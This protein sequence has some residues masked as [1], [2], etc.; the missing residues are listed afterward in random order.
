MLNFYCT[1]LLVVAV[2]SCNA[3]ISLLDNKWKPH[4]L[5]TR[6]A[7]AQV[8][9]S[10]RTLRAGTCFLSILKGRQQL[11]A[12]LEKGSPSVQER[13]KLVISA[14]GFGDRRQCWSSV[15][16]GETYILFLSINNITGYLVAKYLGAFGAAELLYGP[17]ED[18]I[19]LS[20]GWR[21]WSSWS[22]CSRGCGGGVR[23]RKRVC[24]SKELCHG[25]SEE[26]KK[27]NTFKCKGFVD[28][29]ESIKNENAF[30]DNNKYFSGN[31]FFGQGLPVA[32]NAMTYL[33]FPDGLPAEFSL[34][35]TFKASVYLPRYIFS[36]YD[37][38]NRMLL[39]VKLGPDSI[40]FSVGRVNDVYHDKVTHSFSADFRDD[41]W[42]QLGISVSLT[43]IV[44]TEECNEVGKVSVNGR[45]VHN[46]DIFGAAYIGADDSEGASKYFH[47]RVSQ[48]SMVPDPKA[49]RMQCG[50]RSF[51]S[52][53]LGG[54]Q[55][56]PP[57]LAGPAIEGR[58][59]DTSSSGDDNSGGE[60]D[61]E[62]EQ[63]SGR[64]ECGLEC[65]NGAKCVNGT[66]CLC[67]PGW[68]GLDCGIAICDPPCKNSG[69]C[70][71]P[72]VCKCTPKFEGSLCQKAV[73]DP[74][75]L[76]GGVCATRRLKCKCPTGFFGKRCEHRTCSKYV[77][78]QVS[79]LRPV[80]RARV[81]EYKV[82]CG[83]LKLWK[84]TKKKLV[85]YKSKQ[86]SYRQEYVCA[87]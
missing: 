69:S 22:T 45:L 19:L 84:C 8:V 24:I 40:T 38:N 1:L 47:G 9:V 39:G 33:I 83:I 76:N 37:A 87:H 59:Q 49:L 16:V 60:I 10:T 55:P 20:L 58:R 43:G 81:K 85:Y 36:M 82:P 17:S 12:L 11:K 63:G 48:I 64:A 72:G 6:A 67:L 13:D 65:L 29:L 15:D 50:R 27:C 42:H 41:S 23:R 18:A 80:T 25:Q 62:D 71:S 4:S 77:T 51:L 35:I 68:T 34:F 21:S 54:R 70:L 26:S 75:C 14:L 30:T 78:R 28:V 52:S 2:T 61:G 46:F 57:Y 79:Y 74:S 86:T 7:V 32:P 73:C 5:E 44:V 3:C 53:S 31:M 56:A 66:S